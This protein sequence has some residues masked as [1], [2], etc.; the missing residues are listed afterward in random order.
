MFIHMVSELSCGNQ[1]YITTASLF[2]S[3]YYQVDAIL[4]VKWELSQSNTNYDEL[5]K[6]RISYCSFSL[7]D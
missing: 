5:G 3:C 4:S 2:L 1:V 7:R 6:N